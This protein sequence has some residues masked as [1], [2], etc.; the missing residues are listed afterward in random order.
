MSR[1]TQRVEMLKKDFMKY[2]NNGYSIREIADV[3]QVDFSTVYN[4]LQEIADTHGVTRESLLERVSS[5]HTS[6]SSF[7]KDKTDVEE[8][9][10]S[11]NKVV[12][13]IDEV[14]TTIDKI[15]L[16]TEKEI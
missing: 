9:R 10:N 15:L 1:T 5:P 11:F 12:K 2:H 4:H 7:R 16:T 13:D 14:V 8:L 3:F 6:S